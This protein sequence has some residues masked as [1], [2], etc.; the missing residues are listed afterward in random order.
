M[1]S[2]KETS[3]LSSLESKTQ[4]R[5]SRYQ[6]P[7]LGL[8]RSERQILL[9]VVD[10]LLL[11]T[12]LVLSLAL[13]TNLLP[14][15]ADLPAYSKWFL[16][17]SVVWLAV[18]AVFDV[19][20]LARAASSTHSAAAVSLAA[21]VASLTYLAIPWFTPTQKNRT[22]GFL[23]VLA[24]VA[25][26]AT[27]R[28]LYARLF[29][30]PAFQRRALVVGAGSSGRDLAQALQDPWAVQDANP[31]RGTGHILV[32]FVD[33]NH[34]LQ[35][36]IVADLPVL[37]TSEALLPLVNRLA[38][39]EV[40]IA[41]THP[42]S[43]Q[44]ALFEAL[45]DCREQGVPITTMT[46]IYERLTGRVAIE[47][48]S[49]N[50]ELAAGQDETL[51]RRFHDSVKRL[52]DLAGAAL[53]SLVLLL[54]I[55]LVAL[56]NALA[57]PGPLFFRQ[58]RVGRGGQPFMV[59]KFRSMIP[60][61]EK[62]HGAIWAR[63]NDERITPFGR[64]LRKTH[65]DELPQVL[66]VLRGEMSLVGPRPERPEFVQ[67]LSQSIPFYRARHCVRP[68][69]TG[70]A[71]IHQ[72]YGDSLAGAKEKLEYDLFYVKHANLYLDTLILLRTVSKVL[73]L[74]GR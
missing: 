12:A 66:N 69:I 42:H 2:L 30:Q 55:P 6:L 27:W 65:L 25:L 1:N 54:F 50:L 23:F 46:T 51:F 32:G 19:Y 26:L 28:V 21:V 58:Q 60:N 4:K 17:L 48:A 67:T 22:Q 15:V 9:F 36:A 3:S 5:S 29:I 43:I 70:W 14:P 10:L 31:F 18:A 16:T 63:R 72:D 52:G 24:A 20:N 37:G 39:D 74:R 38:V 68:G 61:A 64:L 71:Q 47:H 35:E 34:A 57:S 33:D 7:S 44:P 8:R 62:G 40:I 13:R 45:L 49:R 53:G 41:I 73:G 11:N 59:I 56:G